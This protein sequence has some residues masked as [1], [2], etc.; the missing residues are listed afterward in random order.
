MPENQEINQISIKLAVQKEKIKSLEKQLYLQDKLINQKI[1]NLEQ[2]INNKIMILD[3]R[4][5]NINQ[6]LQNI[7]KNFRSFSI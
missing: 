3:Q 4:I 5:N 6:Q 7:L 2:D 1:V